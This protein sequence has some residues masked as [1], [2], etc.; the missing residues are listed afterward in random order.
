MICVR[1][2]SIS[3]KL[4]ALVL[5]LLIA[6]TIVSVHNYSTIKLHIAQLTLRIPGVPHQW[7]IEVIG[8]D[9][10]QKIQ[11]ILSDKDSKHKMEDGVLM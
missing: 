2:K 9:A 8:D 10:V 4:L 1:M 7:A 5:L 6:I 3:I 11:T